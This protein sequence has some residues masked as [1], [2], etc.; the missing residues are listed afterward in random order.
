VCKSY[1]NPTAGSCFRVPYP[2][3]LQRYGMVLRHLP[4]QPHVTIA[5]IPGPTNTRLAH[6]SPAQSP[7]R[8]KRR[9][10]GGRIYFAYRVPSGLKK[11]VAKCF[12]IFI[13]V[14][15]SDPYIIDFMSTIYIEL[16][17]V[18]VFLLEI[19]FLIMIKI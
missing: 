4:S 1:Y 17:N 14:Y 3:F 15:R 7:S 18:R 12:R 16:K 6:D 19:K 9:R 11:V 10:A 2:E 13:L 8:K 5:A